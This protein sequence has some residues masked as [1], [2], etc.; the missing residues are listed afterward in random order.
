MQVGKSQQLDSN[1]SKSEVISKKD[2][3]NPF[4]FNKFGKEEKINLNQAGLERE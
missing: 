4:N 1:A 3:K 2:K